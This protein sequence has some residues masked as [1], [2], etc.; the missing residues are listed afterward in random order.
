M[1]LCGPKPARRLGH[2]LEQADI[3]GTVDRDGF[4]ETRLGWIAHRRLHV[5]DPSQ[6][7]AIS[8]ALGNDTEDIG[9]IQTR[10]G[11]VRLEQGV[12][13]AALYAGRKD[14]LEEPVGVFRRALSNHFRVQ[15][16]RPNFD[17]Q[18]IGDQNSSNEALTTGRNRPRCSSR[19]RLATE[20]STLT[21]SRLAF[22]SDFGKH[23]NGLDRPD[24]FHFPDPLQVE[25]VRRT[26][27][28]P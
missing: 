1:W 2:I 10:A 19:F 11:Q 23:M 25:S 20:L 7:G 13:M 12:R 6:R 21:F 4:G 27:V 28:R 14:F 26:G 9:R 3:H 16:G 8:A 17:C 15:V 22:A 5:G 24:G 18:L